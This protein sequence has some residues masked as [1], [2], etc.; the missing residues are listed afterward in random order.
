MKEKELSDTFKTIFIAVI[1][2]LPGF[3]ILVIRRSL[4]PNR[5]I[6]TLDSV[7]ACFGMSVTVFIIVMLL[8]CIIP[9]L[10]SNLNAG[11][12][13]NRL[14][15]F[16][17]L[18]FVTSVL[19]IY[20]VLLSDEKQWLYKLANHLGLGVAAPEPSAWVYQFG[21]R[22]N[23]YVIVHLKD[24]ESIYGWYG[25]KSFVGIKPGEKDLFLEEVYEP[26]EP[27]WKVHEDVN[28]LY[29]S[30]EEIKYIEFLK[31]KEETN[32]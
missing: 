17:L 3:L 5:E 1:C 27:T 22:E 26:T 6:T 21:K 23:S 12:K 9:N 31:L 18:E 19:L 4:Y 13:L 7:L 28:G 15:I 24:G 8:T 25:D 16:I 30:A 11:D 10:Q 32:E 20:P 14:I 29:I 2:L